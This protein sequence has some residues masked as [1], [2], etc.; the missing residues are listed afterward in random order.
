MS[1]ILDNIVLSTASF[2]LWDI[3]I[4]EKLEHCKNLG[5]KNIQ[6]A[7]STLSMLKNLHENFDNLPLSHFEDVSIHAPWCGVKYGNNNR[8]SKVMD[9]LRSIDSHE[10]I[11]RYVFNHD[12]ILDIDIL[13]DSKLNLVIRNPVNPNSWNDFASTIKEENFPCVFDLN[14]AIRS[15]NCMDTLINEI[16]DFTSAIHLSGFIDNLNRMPIVETKQEGLLKYLKKFNR[17]SPPIIIEGLFSPRDLPSI[18]ME[19]DLIK[20]YYM[21]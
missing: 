2:C 1:D 18:L 11:S 4:Y 5:F 14:K 6:I 7:V 9:Y 17:K 16:E 3:C 19:V 8:T 10:T 21:Q 13:H 12:T 20:N 15:N